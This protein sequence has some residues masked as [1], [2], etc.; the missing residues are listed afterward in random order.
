MKLC[1][2]N[3]RVKGNFMRL[4][5]LFSV[6]L[7]SLISVETPLRPSDAGRKERA[8]ERPREHSPQ[9]RMRPA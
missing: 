7:I 6:L 4:F 8:H 3:L 9:T 2:L 1:G 5:T